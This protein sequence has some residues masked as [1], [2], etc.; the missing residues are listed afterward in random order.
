MSYKEIKIPVATPETREILIALLAE[1][2]HEGFEET[3][4]A[5]LSYIP[6]ELFSRESLDNVLASFNLSYTITDIEK[7]NW[8]KEWE[9]SFEPVVIP[10]FCTIRADFH[11]IN[12]KTL[13]EIIITPKMSFGT[14]HHATTQIMIQMMRDINFVEKKVLDFGTGTGILAI[15]AGQLGSKN[16][17]AID[18][19]EWSYTNAIENVERNRVKGIKVKCATL[20]DILVRETFDVILANINRHILLQYMQALYQITCVGGKL[21]MSGLLVEDTEIIRSKAVRVGFE[22][23]QLQEN[24]NWIGILVSKPNFSG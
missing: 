18:N 24:K 17:L 13:H 7:T 4:S 16:V 19:D 6:E 2:G 23:K 21:L 1:E 22:I 10:G 5:L 11:K 8:N 12:E 3:E 20:D 9:S 15:L 14:G